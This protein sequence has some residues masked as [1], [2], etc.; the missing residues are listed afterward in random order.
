MAGTIEKPFQHHGG[1]Y[2][3]IHTFGHNTIPRSVQQA[4]NSDLKARVT[5][6][7]PYSLNHRLALPF[8]VWTLINS[9][10]RQ[11]VGQMFGLNPA[12]NY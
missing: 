8:R 5:F 1:I 7:C 12:E 4:G 10:G 9:V 6:S 3:C 11:L 2:E